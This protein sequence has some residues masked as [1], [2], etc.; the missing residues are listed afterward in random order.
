MPVDWDMVGALAT[1]IVP[2]TLFVLPLLWLGRAKFGRAIGYCV[3]KVVLVYTRITSNNVV[4]YNRV[5][6]HFLYARRILTLR[7]IIWRKRVQLNIQSVIAQDK[8]LQEKSASNNERMCM[9][10]ILLA[11]SLADDTLIHNDTC[12][13]VF[14]GVRNADV[15]RF[16]LLCA[17]IAED[18]VT[19]PKAQI[20]EV[21]FNYIV[22]WDALLEEFLRDALDEPRIE[23]PRED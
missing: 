14:A 20:G 11:E 18:I 10:A 4:A 5:S 2:I 17:R 19:N 6:E 8:S 1:I 13:Q 12:R 21:G 9:A 7:W 22:S 15:G 3:R 16:R 23:T